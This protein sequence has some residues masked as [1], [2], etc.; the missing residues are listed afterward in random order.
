MPGARCQYAA[1]YRIPMLGAP[2]ALTHCR[3][4]KVRS[5]RKL[6]KRPSGRRDNSTC[7]E[8]GWR[9]S[10]FDRIARFVQAW[11]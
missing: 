2:M 1:D 8:S 6:T 3:R 5:P 10:P 11:K 9:S 7:G 4:T